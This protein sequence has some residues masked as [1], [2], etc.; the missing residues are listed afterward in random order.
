MCRVDREW[1]SDHRKHDAQYYAAP[2]PDY[3]HSYN[4]RNWQ[5]AFVRSMSGFDKRLAFPIFVPTQ[6]VAKR[7]A[8]GIGTTRVTE[9]A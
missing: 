6:G 4:A 8:R 7:R 9:G 2:K 1:A 3:Q 5:I